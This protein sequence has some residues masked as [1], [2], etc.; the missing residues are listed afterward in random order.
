MKNIIK[1]S[2]TVILSAIAGSLPAYGAFL[3]WS[4]CMAQVPAT[5]A[6][7]GLIKVL[8]TLGMLL[9]GTSAVL[10]CCALAGFAAGAI[11]FFLFDLSD[12]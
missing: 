1:L 2:T 6:M 4:W 11:C 10:A 3:L 8:I 5:I 12:I 7:A 9:F